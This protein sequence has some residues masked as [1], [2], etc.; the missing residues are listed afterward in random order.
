MLVQGTSPENQ[1][2]FGVD[3][4]MG[5]ATDTPG[6]HP[7]HNPNPNPFGFGTSVPTPATLPMNTN[8]QGL[9]GFT[10]PMGCGLAWEKQ[11]QD[12]L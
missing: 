11:L 3:P 10:I 5:R 6:Y 9:H 4:T 12:T 1:R 2:N 7:V 8:A